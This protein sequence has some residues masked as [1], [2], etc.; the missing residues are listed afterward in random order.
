MLGEVFEFGKRHIDEFESSANLSWSERGELNAG[1]YESYHSNES[2]N[3]DPACF[4]DSEFPIDG[5]VTVY[6]TLRVGEDDG[7]IET[8][9]FEI[10]SGDI[11][12]IDTPLGRFRVKFYGPTYFR[13]ESDSVVNE[14]KLTYGIDVWEPDLGQW[15]AVERRSGTNQGEIEHEFDETTLRIVLAD[16]PGLHPEVDFESLVRGGL[17][18]AE[19]LDYWMVEFRKNTQEEWAETRGRTQQAIS[20]NI[21]AARDKL[22]E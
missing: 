13:H 1:F 8:E 21:A 7:T 19:A 10:D 20:K 5:P 11:V 3:G 17:S 18:P 14:I 4:N 2:R 15:N 22:A 12:K 16:A 6:I 9:T